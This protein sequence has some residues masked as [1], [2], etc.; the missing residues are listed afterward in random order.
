MSFGPSQAIYQK[1]VPRWSTS[2]SSDQA[3]GGPPDGNGYCNKPRV[4]PLGYKD[5]ICDR[6]NTASTSQWITAAEAWFDENR[7]AISD[8]A[9]AAAV[10]CGTATIVLSL[11][12]SEGPN[13]LTA[14]CTE[15]PW[16]R[17][18]LHFLGIEESHVHIEHEQAPQP[19]A[20]PA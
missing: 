7:Q 14:A 20:V 12:G 5:P 6:N 4:L 16:V 10:A 13:V 3:S 1:R 19:A 18:R 17:W 11:S 15:L 9:H 2:L 8:D